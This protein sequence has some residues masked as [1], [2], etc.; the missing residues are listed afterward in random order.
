MFELCSSLVCTRF[1]LVSQEDC[2]VLEKA[3]KF[4]GAKVLLQPVLKHFVS[5]GFF[6]VVCVSHKY[7]CLCSYKP[8]ITRIQ[9]RL[10]HVLSSSCNSPVIYLVVLHAYEEKIFS[11]CRWFCVE[12]ITFNIFKVLDVKD[13]APEAQSCKHWSVRQLVPLVSEYI[14]PWLHSCF[15]NNHKITSRY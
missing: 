12:C 2:Y 11:P 6:P 8:R 14:S 1:Q 4:S 15:L 10:C 13:L 9:A 3:D 7:I 5:K